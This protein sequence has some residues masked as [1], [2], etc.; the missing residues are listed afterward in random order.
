MNRSCQQPRRLLCTTEIDTMALMGRQG[1]MC[2]LL[3]GT[4][5]LAMGRVCGFEFTAWDDPQN[6][7]NN[8]LINPPTL[9]HVAKFWITPVESLYIPLTYT[10]WAGVAHVAWTDAP[11]AAGNHLNPY[12]F[13]ALN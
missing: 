9:G 11:D 8:P 6:L 5:L 13:H 2:A 12:V 3:V 7:L 4:T 10:I 1:W